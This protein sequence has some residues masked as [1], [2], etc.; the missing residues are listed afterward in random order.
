MELSNFAEIAVGFRLLKSSVVQNSVNF[1]V[2]FCCLVSADILRTNFDA[3][4]ELCYQSVIRE[5]YSMF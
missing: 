5:Y 1:T 3:G 2:K 4:I